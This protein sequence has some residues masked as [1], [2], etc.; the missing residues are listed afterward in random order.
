MP[1]YTGLCIECE[2]VADYIRPVDERLD[3]PPCR[4]CGSEISLAILTPPKTFV[5]G[6]FQAFRSTVDGTIID[7]H[8]AMDEHNK[9]NGVVCLADGYSNESI[10]AG[11]P[12]KKA[13]KLDTK[14]L[15]QDIAEAA[16]HVRDG[17]KPEVHSEQ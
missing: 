12:Q 10:L 15:M 7:S 17:Y 1:V 6:R 13:E 9:R 5:R 14:E 8:R 3:T 16:I 4:V 11:L 2:A